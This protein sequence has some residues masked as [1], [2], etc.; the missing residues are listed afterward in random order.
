MWRVR[1]TTDFM[2]RSVNDALSVLREPPA[3]PASLRLNAF[4]FDGNPPSATAR[5]STVAEVFLADVDLTTGDAL[6]RAIRILPGASQIINNTLLQLNASNLAVGALVAQPVAN[7]RTRIRVPVPAIR[8]TLTRAQFDTINR[9]DDGITLNF[10]VNVADSGNARLHVNATA[11]VDILLTTNDAVVAAGAYADGAA[12][13]NENSAIGTPVF[14]TPLNVTDNDLLRPAGDIYTYGLQVTR[15]G[16][17]VADLLRWNVTGQRTPRG[18]EEVVSGSRMFNWLQRDLVLARSPDDVDVGAY[19]VRWTVN[20]TRGETVFNRRVATGGFNLTIVNQE[21]APTVYCDVSNAT[22]ACGYEEG[23]VVLQDVFGTYDAPNIGELRNTTAQARV[24]FTDPDLLALGAAALPMVANLTLTNSTDL[25]MGNELDLPTE[26]IDLGADVT[27]ARLGVSDR[28]AVTVPIAL[29]L[30][31]TNYDFINQRA[32]ATLNFKLNLAHALGTTLARARLLFRTR[33]NNP[34]I[35]VSDGFTTALSWPEGTAADTA[36]VTEP[37]H[38]NITDPDVTRQSGDNYTYGLTVTGDNGPVTGLLAWNVG[39]RETVQ[40][41]AQYFNRTIVFAK[42]LDDVDVGLY[43]VDL[44]DHRCPPYPC[45][46]YRRGRRP[47]YT[48]HYK[49]Q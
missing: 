39:M 32:S 22:D 6:P 43:T 46:G 18:L 48:E 20:E 47:F 29:H 35:N 19:Q 31:R 13:L 49:C 40:Q 44:V 36:L 37:L 33:G 45:C 28:F 5:A 12:R 23:T 24:V 27:I 26:R 9:R 7:N 10:T 41:E 25:P 2:I 38:F 14:D 3:V 11:R 4:N 21:E 16:Q 1:L 17:P 8:I 34:M 42:D 30:T 15:E